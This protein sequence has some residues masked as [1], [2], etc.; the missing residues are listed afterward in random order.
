MPAHSAKKLTQYIK[1]LAQELGFLSCGISKA[2]FLEED[3]PRLEQFLKRNY[4]GEMRYLENHFDKRLDP[5]KLVEGAKSVISFSYN[6]YPAQ[7]QTTDTYKLAKYA[8]GEDY[9]HVIR[10]LLRE[11]VERLRPLTGD[12]VHRIFV[13][14]APVLEKS[15]AQKSGLGWV[16]KNGN[17]LTP[18]RGSF[19]LLAEVV[20]DLDLEYD[21]PISD[22]CGTCR[23]CI[24]ACPTQAI[25]EERVVDGSQCISYA[26]IEL[27]DAIPNDFAGKMED[28][29]FGCDICQ[30][31]C[32]WNRFS[33][34]HQEAKFMA[35]A[36]KLQMTKEDW[37]HLDEVT[38]TTLFRKSAVKRTK[39]AGLMRNI[40]F[41]QSSDV[42]LSDEKN[43]K[44]HS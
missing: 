19:Y 37:Q 33:V 29:M 38:F 40:R 18:R 21:A 23:R 14:S 22:H 20:C 11:F 8:Y 36:E 26:T 31:V 27:K 7:K 43:R 25:V 35:M 15:W 13:D 44:D 10:D 1:D 12:F 4:Q 30:D 6:Y 39:Y 28:W 32:P 16:G 41:L 24:D 9:H 2:G 34:P 5:T 3:A 42:S 17:L